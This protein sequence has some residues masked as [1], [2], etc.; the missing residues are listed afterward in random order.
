[1]HA[2]PQVLLEPVIPAVGRPRLRVEGQR[3]RLA[4]GIQL[5]PGRPQGGEDGGVVDDGRGD[6]ERRRAEQE[7]RVR[8][9]AA[10]P[11]TLQLADSDTR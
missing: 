7:V 4:E 8:R 1:M 11:K 10:L 5:E 6:G 3:E 9:R 2:H